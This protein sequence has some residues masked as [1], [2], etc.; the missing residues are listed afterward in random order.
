MDDNSLSVLFYLTAVAKQ[1]NFLQF[2]KLQDIFIGVSAKVH[3]NTLRIEE[4]TKFTHFHRIRDC[5]GSPP[6]LLGSL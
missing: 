5:G 6:P 1:H 4:I 2:K 3:F